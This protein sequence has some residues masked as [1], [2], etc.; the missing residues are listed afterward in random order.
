MTRFKLFFSK[1]ER[2]AKI[3]VTSLLLAVFALVFGPGVY[4]QFAR[5]TGSTGWGYGYGYGYGSDYGWDAGALYGYRTDVSTDAADV[6]AYAY[7]YGYISENTTYSTSTGEYL[8]DSADLADLATMGV[9]T[10]NIG[11]SSAS[12]TFVQPVVLSIGS[13]VTLDIAQGTVMSNEDAATLATFSASTT[14]DITD[15][16]SDMTSIGAFQFGLTD[17]GMTIDPGIVINITVG[18]TYNGRYIPIYSKEPDGD[19]VLTYSCEVANGI[20]SFTAT[21]LSDFAAATVTT[22]TNSSSGGGGG[23]G[24]VYNSNIPSITAT[25]TNPTI[26]PTTKASLVVPFKS[27]VGYVGKLKGGNGDIYY[28]EN[29]IKHRFLNPTVMK[30]WFFKSDAASTKGVD[31]AKAKVKEISASD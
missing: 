5:Q 4:A 6:F 16:P 26:N 22:P 9:I 27:T 28:I 25:V 18:T 8:V 15:L 17:Y 11:A 31:W 21:S 30:S 13:N 14:V 3:I 24:Y 20:C 29:G 10:A 2:V 1:E 23:G 12:L 19:W 7:G